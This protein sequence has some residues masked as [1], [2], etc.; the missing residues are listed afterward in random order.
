[1]DKTSS[2]RRKK[3]GKYGHVQS[4]IAAGTRARA[5]MP[6]LDYSFK[7]LTEPLGM[8]HEEPRSGFRR[9]IEVD[10]QE[11]QAAAAQAAVLGGL[12][13]GEGEV[14]ERRED[15]GPRGITTAIRLCNNELSH[16]GGLEEAL[17]E[18]L[19]EPS[20]LK[21]IDLSFN[22]LDDIDEVLTFF[23]HLTTLYLHGNNIGGAEEY[24]HDPAERGGVGIGG[25]DDDEEEAAR[26]AAAAAARR[27]RRKLRLD[28]VDKLGLL[29]N[30]RSLTL[31]GNPIESHPHYKHY[32]LS[33]CP[34]LRHLDFT[35][36]TKADHR[37][38][39]TW[40]S[41]HSARYTRKR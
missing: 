18:V 6:P 21:W 12:E 5:T 41:I 4:R 1:M 35:G 27:K 9:V 20:E 11:I 15:A 33:V 23:P 10:E 14:V 8:V 13:V 30:L 2:P 36:V 29:P 7:E 34:G 39:Q 24:V 32:V 31:H 26:A 38:A 28:V 37:A 3:K 22:A 17:A 40:A 25:D 19:D 16:L